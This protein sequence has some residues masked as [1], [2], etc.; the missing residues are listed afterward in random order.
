[1][2]ADGLERVRFSLEQLPSNLG[3]VDGLRRNNQIANCVRHKMDLPFKSHTM[4]A[5]TSCF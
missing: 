3:R 5:V 4:L 1:M 2:G